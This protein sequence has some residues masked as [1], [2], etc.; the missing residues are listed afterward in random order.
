MEEA[1]QILKNNLDYDN[2]YYFYHETGQGN[3]REI[4]DEGLLSVS[5]KLVSSSSKP[6]K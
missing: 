5:E 6:I 1:V 3:G 4:C 2:N